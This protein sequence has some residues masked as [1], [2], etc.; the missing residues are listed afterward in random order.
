MELAW[1]QK[2]EKREISASDNLALEYYYLG[3]L[4][5]ASHYNDWMMRGKVESDRSVVKKVTQNVIVSK[6]RRPK[7]DFF[8]N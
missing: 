7:Y 1:E 6:R 8:L 4:E 3:D 2:D 5:K